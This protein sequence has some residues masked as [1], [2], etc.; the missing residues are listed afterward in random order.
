MS[1]NMTM[2]KSDKATKRQSDKATKRQSELEK[3]GVTL[4]RFTDLEVKKEMFSVLLALEQ[5]VSELVELNK[6][7]P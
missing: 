5:K 6:T 1:S 4:L 7:S 3:Y 2:I